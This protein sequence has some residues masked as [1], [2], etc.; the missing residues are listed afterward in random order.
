VNISAIA[1]PRYRKIL[2]RV[3]ITADL[4]SGLEGRILAV[5]RRDAPICPLFDNSGQRRILARDGLSE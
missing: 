1:G 2:A 4:K 3:E 5:I